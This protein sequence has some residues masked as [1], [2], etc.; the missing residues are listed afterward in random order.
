MQRVL[1]KVLREF[2]HRSPH[3]INLFH[4]YFLPMKLC[5][6]NSS[7]RNGKMS[8]KHQLAAV[9]PDSVVRDRITGYKSSDT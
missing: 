7:N 1:P 2:F 4:Q 8:R 6:L 3:V 5:S 9:K